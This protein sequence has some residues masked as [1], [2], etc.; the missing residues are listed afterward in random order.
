M[1]DIDCP[2]CGASNSVSCWSDDYVCGECH[3]H[4]M[5]MEFAEL[6]DMYKNEQR[7]ADHLYDETQNPSDRLRNRDDE[8]ARLSKELFNK[9]LDFCSCGKSIVKEGESCG[10][11]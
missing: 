4:V 8:N 7:R 6:Y 5:G 1:K 11:C 10:E 9:G 2:E 3:E